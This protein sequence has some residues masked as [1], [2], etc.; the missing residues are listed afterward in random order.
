MKITIKINKLSIGDGA[1][2]RI[3]GICNLSRESFYKGSVVEPENVVDQCRKMIEGGAS[4][5]DIGGRSTAPQAA[6]ISVEEEEKRVLK[7]LNEIFN[8]MEIKDTIV[9]IDTQYKKVADAAFSVFKKQ[10]CEASFVL[11][12]VSSL[13]TDPELADWI[14]D[15]D[16]PVILMASHSRPGDPLGMESTLEALEKSIKRLDKKGYKCDER[17]IVDP[18]IGRWVPEKI[19]SYDTEI[20]RDLKRLRSLGKPVLAGISRK[21]FIGYLVNQP[22]PENRF[23]GTLSATAVAVFNGAHIIRTHDVTAST[24]DVI[25]TAAALRLLNEG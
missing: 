20:I 19:P 25:T 12:D 14:T 7:A 11:N 8:N 16:K 22:D 24:C 6:P 10:G 5:L 17:I 9:S 15:V 3:M 1:P 13:T 23:F 18:A 21:S 2:V 4:L